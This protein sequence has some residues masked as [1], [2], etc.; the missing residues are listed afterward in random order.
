MKLATYS[1]AGTP[2]I[3]I[4]H[5][6]NRRVFDLAHAA[7]LAGSAFPGFEGFWPC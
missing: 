7:A 1:V 5:D 3:G 4:V 2:R 6:D